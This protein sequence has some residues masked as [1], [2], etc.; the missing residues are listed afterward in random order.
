[1]DAKIFKVD[2]PKGEIFIIRLVNQSGCTVEL[3]N[4]G[5][6]ITKIM[7]PDK[8]GHIGDVVLGYADYADYLYDAPCAGKTPGRYANRIANGKFSIDGTEYQLEINNAPNALHGGT[9][10]FHNVLWNLEACSGNSV[11]F[12]Y[13]ASDGEEGYP[14]VLHVSVMYTWSDGNELTI[15][16]NAET[17]K[18]TIVNLT[19]HAYFNLS[20]DNSDSCLDHQLCLNCHRWLP[21]DETDIPIG[22]IDDVGGIPMDFTTPKELG[23][24]ISSDF[25]NMQAGKGYNHFFLIDGW[26]SDGQLRHAATLSDGRSGRRLDVFTTQCGVMLYTGN[27]LADCLSIGKNGRTFADHQGVAIE[28]QGAPDA[29]NHKCFPSQVLRPGETYRQAIR[30]SFS[31]L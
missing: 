22:T 13:D 23:R 27:W 18:P 2:S 30:Y 19:N 28:C 5:A 24:D 12:T 11:K 9:N 8:L 15:E 1:M 10:G 16:Y 4:L 17:D 31:L 26:C 14:G 21:A 7:V 25:S 20:G 3:S 29:P 6:G